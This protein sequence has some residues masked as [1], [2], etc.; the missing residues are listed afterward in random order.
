VRQRINRSVHSRCRFLLLTFAE[1]L[2][3]NRKQNNPLCSPLRKTG[4]ADGCVSETRPIE[5]QIPCRDGRQHWSRTKLANGRGKERLLA[6]FNSS[7]I[8][9]K[10]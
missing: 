1:R 7:P 6:A 2:L 8:A 10:A 4:I 5:F 9:F 3:R